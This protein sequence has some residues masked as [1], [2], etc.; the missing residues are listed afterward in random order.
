MI[1][2]HVLYFVFT[3]TQRTEVHSDDFKPQVS[4]SRGLCL[5]CLCDLTTHQDSI[6]T[7]K[8]WTKSREMI[9]T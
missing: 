5:M 1:C 3:K 7:E 4:N 6:K 9:S 8:K 2:Y